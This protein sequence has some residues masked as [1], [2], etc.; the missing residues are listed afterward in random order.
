VSWRLAQEEAELEAELRVLAI[1]EP[2]WLITSLIGAAIGAIIPQLAAAVGYPFRRLKGDMFTGVWNEY[3]WTWNDGRKQMWSGRVNVRRGILKSYTVDAHMFPES[4]NGQVVDMPGHASLRHR[5]ELRLEGAHVIL[6]TRA[7]THT[8]SVVTRYP[9]WIPSSS[10]RIVGIWMSFDHSGAPAAG[11]VLLSR[12]K[13]ETSDAKDLL[14]RYVS[15]SPGFL[16]VRDGTT[17]ARGS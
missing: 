5:G 11:A 15:T 2:N 1:A 7:T 17:R 13:I 14:S 9:R 8:E 3:Y 4:G 6:E 12:D 16:R 10:D